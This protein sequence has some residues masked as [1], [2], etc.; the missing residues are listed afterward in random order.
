MHKKNL[1]NA[2]NYNSDSGLKFIQEENYYKLENESLLYLD[3]TDEPVYQI[4]IKL[5]NGVTVAADV[6]KTD[7]IEHL[8]QI[9]IQKGN[10]KEDIKRIVF[11]GKELENERTLSSYNIQQEST[12]HCVLRLR[13]C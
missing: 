1:K 7:T 12:L 11:A 4:F 5:L 3:L 13:G 8:K 9:L 10:N 2:L 6:Q